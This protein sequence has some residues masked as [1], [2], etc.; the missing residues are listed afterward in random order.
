MGSDG[1]LISMG[2]V[3]IG[4]LISVYGGRVLIAWV[5]F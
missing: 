5:L 4:V 3:E 2:F 1:V